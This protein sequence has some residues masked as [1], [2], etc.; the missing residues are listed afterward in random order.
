MSINDEVGIDIPHFA[1]Q[2]VTV[3]IGKRMRKDVR[4]KLEALGISLSAT[5]EGSFT[6]PHSTLKSVRMII[7]T[8]YPT[9]VMREH[10]RSAVQHHLYDRILWGAKQLPWGRGIYIGYVDQMP[11]FKYGSFYDKSVASASPY[12][13]NRIELT[14]ELPVLPYD[15]QSRTHRLTFDTAE[16]ARLSAEQV[17]EAFVR[18][19]GASFEDETR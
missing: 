14:S 12:G 7:A 9:W 5:G 15:P 10:D 4:E 11:L 13:T 8:S 18:R 16:E 2:K 6:I 17:L 1:N 3:T 19:L